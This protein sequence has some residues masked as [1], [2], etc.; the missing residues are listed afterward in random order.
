MNLPG[1]A[2]STAKPNVISGKQLI[3]VIGLLGFLLPVLLIVISV[4][5]GGCSIV[6]DSISAYYFTVARNV[7]VGTL[8]ALSISFLVYKGY[9]LFDEWLANA[10]SLFAL[11]VAFFPT[12]I[13]SADCITDNIGASVVSKVHFISAG[14]LFASFVVFS[15]LL[16]TK[17]DKELTR[18]KIIENK[19]YR[20]CGYTIVV[21]IVGIF[22]WMMVMDQSKYPGI[23][24]LSPVFWLES[25][26]LWAFSISWLT[27]GKLF[28]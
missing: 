21:A 27:K 6:Q 16:F 1:L 9:S 7:F 18:K 4:T 23:A 25:V 28:Q 12:S 15:L 26:A 2:N 13:I 22:I 8:C 24:E 10:A 3:S 20:I 11:G 19:V 17:T 5:Q 14:L